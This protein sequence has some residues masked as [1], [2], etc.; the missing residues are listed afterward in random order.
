VEVDGGCLRRGRIV[1]IR[2]NMAFGW[3]SGEKIRFAGWGRKG[4]ERDAEEI[5]QGAEG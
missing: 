5:R 3:V 2:K 4:V 1:G